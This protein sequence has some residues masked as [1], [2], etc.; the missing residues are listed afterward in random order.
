MRVGIVN[1]GMGNLGS[2]ASALS[3]LGV[4]SFTSENPVELA[5]ADALILPGVGAFAQ[6]MKNLTQAGLDSFLTCQVL[7]EG[8]PF[9]GI[10]LGMQ[11]L[12]EDSVE[13]GFTQGLGWIKGH[14]VPIPSSAEFQV[15]HVGWNQIR[16]TGE[17]RLL[18]RIGDDAHFYFDHSFHYACTDS[19]AVVAVCDYGEPR[20]AML[21]KGNIFASQFHPEKSQRNG[22]KLLRN[23]LNF[24]QTGKRT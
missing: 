3:W 16:I 15:P 9:L 20:V 19:E 14:I 13:F 8:K 5:E 7:D 12:A 6:A 4:G 24:A 10:C 1:Y 17:S 18:D 11:L 2:V 22:L 21:E 23:F